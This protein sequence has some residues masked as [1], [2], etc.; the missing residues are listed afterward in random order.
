MSEERRIFSY[1]PYAQ[2]CIIRIHDMNQERVKD[3]VTK[4]VNKINIVKDESIFMAYD[5]DIW[6]KYAGEWVQKVIL[7]GK[8]ISLI[9]QELKVEITRNRAVTLEIR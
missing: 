4:L 2:F 9:L 3:I 1:P 7:K 6:E 8:D 5:R